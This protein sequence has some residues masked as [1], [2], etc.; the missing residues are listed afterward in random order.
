VA[1]EGIVV[2]KRPVERRRAL[3]PGISIEK[4]ES[5]GADDRRVERISGETDER[6]ARLLFPLASRRD[7]RPVVRL[8]GLA[9]PFLDVLFYPPERLVAVAPRLTARV[10]DPDRARE[11]G[12]GNTDAV[13]GP[14]VDDH[15]RALRHMAL[16]AQV[17]VARLPLE[18]TFVK[19][20]I[21]AVVHVGLVTARAE[22][23]PF[24]EEL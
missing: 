14:P 8:P 1:D 4:R 3:A 20:V 23:V 9:V 17:P 2:G 24:L 6:G 16:D 12:A 10:G 11:V 21:V 13:I 7:D 18:N 22:L 19:V 15:V 5:G